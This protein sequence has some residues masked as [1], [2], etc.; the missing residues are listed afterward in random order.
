MSQLM[1]GYGT[2]RQ[3]TKTDQFGRNRR[4]SGHA[5]KPCGAFVRRELPGTD[6]SAKIL[7]RCTASL[8]VQ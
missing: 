5:V 1:S 2:S 8:I 6:I 7:L 3:F 4:H